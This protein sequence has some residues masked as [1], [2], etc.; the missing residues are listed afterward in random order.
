MDSF[1][2]EVF[3]FPHGF[4]VESTGTPVDSSGL[5]G[6]QHGLDWTLNLMFCNE[7]II[8]AAIEKACSLPDVNNITLFTDSIASARRAV[9]AT[10][11]DSWSTMFQNEKYRGHNFLLLQNL[12]GGVVQP[13]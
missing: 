11:L 12:N 7:T 9:T 2:F 10:C 5:R 13:T 8:R 4:H 3:T 1:Q 6:T